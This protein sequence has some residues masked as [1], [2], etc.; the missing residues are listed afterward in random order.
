MKKIGYLLVVVLILVS[1]QKEQLII[2]VV[3]NSG[4]I[5]NPNHKIRKDIVSI[6][7]LDTLDTLVSKDII[8]YNRDFY[9]TNILIVE[10]K[11]TDTFQ[12]Y[13]FKNS[14]NWV[15]LNILSPSI[16]DW[17]RDIFN[18]TGS[19]NLITIRYNDHMW[20]KG[21]YIGF[22]NSGYYYQFPNLMFKMFIDPSY[23]NI[24]FNEEGKAM[25]RLSKLK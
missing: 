18:G 15:D 7:L 3:S 11:I 1:C 24:I 9:E 6:T 20:D 21:W 23:P 8:P 2:P 22:N 5:K 13:Y 4:L 19:Y 10:G 16:T 25:I 12:M 17:G 14:P